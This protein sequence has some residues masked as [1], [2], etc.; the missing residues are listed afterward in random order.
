MGFSRRWVI[1]TQDRLSQVLRLLGNVRVNTDTPMELIFRTEH[2]PKSP[3]QRRL[4]HAICSDIAK[5]MGLT[6]AEVKWKIKASFYG[7]E[8]YKV[9]MRDGTDAFWA[10][11][12][13]SEDS[14]KE[15]YSR[16]IDHA[17]RWAAENGV[18]IADR[19]AR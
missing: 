17:Y 3:E 15:E 6:P 9:K 16:L 13:S 18:V 1:P 19:R 12:P 10:D 11:V 8:L 5:E 14:D 7:A 2:A 4:F